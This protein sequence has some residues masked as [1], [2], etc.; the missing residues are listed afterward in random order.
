MEEKLEEWFRRAESLV[1]LDAIESYRNE[2]QFSITC[3]GGLYAWP[4]ASF[5]KRTPGCW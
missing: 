4:Y 5:R 2:N 1:G 3:H